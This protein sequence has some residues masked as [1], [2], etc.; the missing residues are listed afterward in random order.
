MVAGLAPA[1]LLRWRPTT[2]MDGRFPIMVQSSRTRP[3]A[4]GR[5]G[6]PIIE[7]RI[8]DHAAGH[9]RSRTI[10]TVRLKIIGNEIIKKCR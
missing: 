4:V 2:L 7:R 8:A 10:A 6:R 3:M 9:A 5:G 1:N